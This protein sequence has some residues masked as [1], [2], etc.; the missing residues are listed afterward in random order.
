MSELS[1]RAL[2]ALVFVPAVLALV[3]VGGWALFGLVIAMMGN[4][5]MKH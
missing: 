3:Y 5:Q 4:K 1:R 2:S